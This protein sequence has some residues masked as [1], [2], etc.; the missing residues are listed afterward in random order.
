MLKELFSHMSI[1]VMKEYVNVKISDSICID[2]C[3]KHICKYWRKNYVEMFKIHN[4]YHEHQKK[5]I[6]EISG[7]KTMCF[8]SL[9]YN[10]L[11]GKCS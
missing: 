6:F 2:R 5:N 7:I 8:N 4:C 9:C 1:E 3:S 11:T 10:Y